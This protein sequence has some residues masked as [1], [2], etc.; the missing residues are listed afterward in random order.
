[1]MTVK[2][3]DRVYFM[4]IS[5]FKKKKCVQFNETCACTQHL[6]SRQHLHLSVP[7]AFTNI[8]PR[9]ILQ[10]SLLSHLQLCKMCMLIPLNF[11]SFKKK[12]NSKVDGLCHLIIVG[13]EQDGGDV[14]R[15]F[16]VSNENVSSKQ[17]PISAE[18]D[19]IFLLSI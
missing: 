2:Y 16:L 9:V 13:Q 8:V 3:H 19:I 10:T 7:S 1:M 15:I 5:Y 14:C 6:S 11:P 4:N 17:L 12:K 18:M